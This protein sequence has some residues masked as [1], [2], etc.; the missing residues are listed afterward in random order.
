M[1][2][3]LLRTKHQ[4]RLFW[5]SCVI[6]LLSAAVTSLAGA[7]DQQDTS[8]THPENIALNQPYFLN[9]APN[10][11]L[12]LDSEDAGQLTDGFYNSGYF[13]VKKATIG[14]L[15]VQP[16]IITVDLEKVQPISG[17]SFS[18]AVGL[19]GVKWPVA[20]YML[21]SDDGLNFFEVGDLVVLS[22]KHGLPQGS[23]R[24]AYR[25]RTDEL[26]T[27]GRYISFVVSGESSIFVD[28]IEV[29]GGSLGFVDIPHSTRPSQDLNNF[30]KAKKVGEGVKRRLQK[31]V[32][33][34]SSV[35]ASS[36]LP[37]REKQHITEQI[38][39]IERDLEKYHHSGEEDF[40]AVLPLNELHGRIFRAQAELWRAMGLPESS[41]W[42]SGP[43][44][45]LSPTQIPPKGSE[46]SLD[47]TMMLDEYRA[48]AFNVSNASRE[49]MDFRLEILGLPG[50][51]IPPYI[52]VHEVAWTDTSTGQCVA[53]ALPEAKR[54]SGSPVINV[55]SGMTRQVWL[56]FHPTDLQ[57]GKY[58]GQIAMNSLK[59]TTQSAQVPL[60]L[61]V[62]PLRFP[63]QPSLH[64]GGW[65]YTNDVDRDRVTLANRD[66]LISHLRE[67]FV[68]S[69]WATA[70]VLPDGEFG[71]DG[72]FL[73]EPDTAKL[74][75]W[76]KQWP[77]SR[78]Y[79]VMKGARDNFAGSRM[80]TPEFEKKVK[81]W[82]TF[83]AESIKRYG[84][85]PDQLVILLVDE[86]RSP[87]Q[88]EVILHWARAIRAAKTGVKVWEDPV[89]KDPLEAN[90]EMMALCDVLCPNRRMFI[91]Q[92]R[93]RDYYLQRRE[94]G[95][96]LAFYSCSGPMRLLDPY[97]YCRLQAWSCWKYGA[98]SSYFWSF[99]DR[100]GGSSW[101]EYALSG[102]AYVPFFLDEVSVTA[103]KHM[104]AIREGMEDY[105]YLVMLRNT[106]SEV[107][108]KIQNRAI[109]DRARNLL[110]E[111]P[112]RVL[113]AEGANA[114]VWTDRK[115][116]TVADR[117][118]VE[119]LETIV[120][121]LRES[122]P[123]EG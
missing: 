105:E 52:T 4:K 91:N 115:D 15:P 18:T 55:P 96:E 19:A 83:W 21:V 16:V 119:I 70:S 5:I 29:Y 34:I 120:E 93:Q 89:H 79:C 51:T 85:T 14:W 46:V 69:P 11:P 82:I 22:K 123:S 100:A 117:V 95:T 77:K 118:R 32:K 36:I 35:L 47:I 9:P 109:L 106:I 23:E 116:R 17:A 33:D 41:I 72:E 94:R 7:Q 56:T 12:R 61:H 92:A 78:Q 26:K 62:Y 60:T 99:S 65:D 81:K 31:D 28:E 39:E 66:K 102:S 104:E 101:N 42:Q 110:A 59:D 76:V 98:A 112:D 64:L 43:L 86:P 1:R 88:D 107:E 44:E 84:I 2:N 121:L 49:D 57:P 113:D 37:D 50:G 114:Y 108:A 97:S 58:N 54:D 73:K 24:A 38:E 30:F 3:Q 80:G 6:L 68:D 25:F 75:A 103:G 67:H 90:Q 53:S 74:D 20:I 48:G 13:W 40:R 27:H 8:L 87:Q 111:A 63:G 10:Y 122:V 45:P 71:E